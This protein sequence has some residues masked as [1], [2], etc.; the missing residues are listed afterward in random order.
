M[1]S[2]RSEHRGLVP[3]TGITDGH[4]LSVELYK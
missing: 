4:F 3:L 1:V 2:D